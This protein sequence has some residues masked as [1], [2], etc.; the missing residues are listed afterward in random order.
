MRDRTPFGARLFAARTHAKLTQTQLAKAAGVSQGTLGELE[1][2]YDGSAA[3]V[4]LAMACGVRP[5]WLA[6]GSGDMLDPDAWP[7]ELVTLEDVL[8]LDEKQRGIIEG[9][10]LTALD[11]IRGPNP[12]DLERFNASHVRMKKP[13]TR[14]RAA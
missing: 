2:S 13:V 6:E 12:Q 8:A 14:K 5:E 1:W 7:F 4:R 11:R 10:M 3:V 9:A